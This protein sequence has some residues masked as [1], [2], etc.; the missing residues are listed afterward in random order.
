[1]LNQSY[2]LVLVEANYE[3]RWDGEIVRKENNQDSGANI[4]LG[5]GGL[6][7]SLFLPYLVFFIIVAVTKSARKRQLKN[8][9]GEW[10]R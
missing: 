2:Y 9:I 8:Y 5:I 6:L 10:N 7:V 4:G 3:E 1:M